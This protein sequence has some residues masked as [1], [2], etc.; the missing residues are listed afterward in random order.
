MKI[1]P[2]LSRLW[3]VDETTRFEKS[4]VY[5]DAA[6]PFLKKSHN[7][8]VVKLRPHD[9]IKNLYDESYE[10]FLKNR[11][12]VTIDMENKVFL[13]ITPSRE[14]NAAFRRTDGNNLYYS[15]MSGPFTEL[16][17]SSTRSTHW[18][19]A[20]KYR[21]PRLMIESHRTYIGYHP[22]RKKA[23]ID[24]TIDPF[25]I[26][27]RYKYKLLEDVACFIEI[28]RQQKRKIMRRL[29]GTTVKFRIPDKKVSGTETRFG[30]EFTK[31]RFIRVWLSDIEH[32]PSNIST[33]G[34]PR[35]FIDFAFDDG[36]IFLPHSDE[37]VPIGI[38]SSLIHRI[39]VRF[40]PGSEGNTVRLF[41]VS[42][43]EA[44]ILTFILR[45]AEVH[46]GGNEKFSIFQYYTTSE[47]VDEEEFRITMFRPPGCDAILYRTGASLESFFLGPT[48]ATDH[49]QFGRCYH[50]EVD[51]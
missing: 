30:I 24:R 6:L 2:H 9:N 18:L 47:R 10:D 17:D 20:T 1:V 11:Q 41:C 14:C 42:F 38:P 44:L 21:K 49:G 3:I 7:K 34:Q 37:A 5:R 31:C 45:Q 25:P 8:Y 19:G 15:P 36:L 46:I 33:H 22:L 27:K 48:D 12:E 50:F 51:Q 28:R 40:H 13:V 35:D 29:S 23:N 43:F 39:M 26:L 16:R 32:M 4:F